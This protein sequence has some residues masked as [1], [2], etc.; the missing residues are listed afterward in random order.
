MRNWDKT[1]FNK[2]KKLGTQMMKAKLSYIHCCKDATKLT[3][4]SAKPLIP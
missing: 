2:K 1:K 4:V 3:V